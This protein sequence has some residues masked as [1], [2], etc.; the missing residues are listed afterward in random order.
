MRSSLLWPRVRL[1]WR[2][3]EGGDDGA[4]CDG[5]VGPYDCA[6][7][8]F[9]AVLEFDGKEGLLI[10]SLFLEVPLP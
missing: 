5:Y 1:V 10:V 3:G 2:G 9:G 8:P 7:V 6:E 4:Y